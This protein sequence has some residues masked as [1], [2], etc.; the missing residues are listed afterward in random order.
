MRVARNGVR[1]GI[2]IGGT[3]TDLV[4]CHADGRLDASKVSTTPDDPAT[5]VVSNA[6]LQKRGAVAG[7][8]TTKG[9]RDILE[10]GRIRT[11]GMFDLA[12]RK[13]EPL[14]PRR[15]RLEAAERI[16]ADGAVVTALD[17]A[18]VREAAATFL[19]ER[20]EAVAVCFINSYANDAHEHRAAAILRKE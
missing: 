13:P 2:D 14:V 4:L 5:T 15:W 16:G 20:V 12:W 19:A 17:E 7:V 11:P 10:I 6:I 3:F 1:V 8:L 18:S 9:F